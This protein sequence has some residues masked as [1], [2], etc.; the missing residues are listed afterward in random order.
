M[1][2]ISGLLTILALALAVAG[3]ASAAS[4]KK[5]TITRKIQLKSVK[6]TNPAGKIRTIKVGNETNAKLIPFKAQNHLTSAMNSLLIKQKAGATYKNGTVDTVP[7]FNSWFIT[8]SRNSIYTYSM[9]GHSPKTGATTGVNNR[10]LPLEILLT[11]ANGN[12]L[13]DFNPLVATDPEGNDADLLAQSPLYD[14]TTTYPGP[15]ADTGQI[16]DTAQRVEFRSVRAANWHTVLN[17]PQATNAYFVYLDPTAWV[18]LLDSSNNIVGVAI[19]I[20]VASAIY[21]ELLQMEFSVSGLPNSVIPIIETDFVTAFDPS[22]GD[23][24]VLGFHTAET[25]IANPNG[26]LTWTWGTYIPHGVDNG[27]TN[28]FGAFGS[29]IMVLSHE[30]SELF[31]D[32]FVNTNVSPWVDGSASFAQ[33]NLETGDVI[34]GMSVADVIYNVPLTTAGGPYTYS[35]QNVA[36]LEWFTRNPFNGGIYSWPNEGSLSHNPHPVGCQDPL[37]LGIC[38]SYGE[39][40]GG[41]FFG[42]PY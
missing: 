40:S 18:Y 12:V 25:G 35:L 13:Y 21:D 2:K 16:I 39:G 29:D 10:I 1:R 42:P 37:M 14:A 33:A 30:L 28:P 36:T 5:L 26:I 3:V 31:N 24:C 34:E 22:T 7:F 6:G 41:F 23:C 32:P 11:D 17:P 19:D 20:N 27:F 9:V 8:G 4:T 15:P 38:W